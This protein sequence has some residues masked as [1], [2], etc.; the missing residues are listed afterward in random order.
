MSPRFKLSSTI[1]V[2]GERTD[3]EALVAV[4]EDET[5]TIGKRASFSFESSVDAV[6][7]RVHAEDAVALKT[8]ISAL[9]T[10]IRLVE[11]GD[12]DG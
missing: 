11:K 5:R 7:I 10:L 1:L 2:E 12:I 4:L 6:T 3:I 8:A 9:S